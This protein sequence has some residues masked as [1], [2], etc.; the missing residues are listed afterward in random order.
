MKTV[1]SKK[2][3]NPIKPSKA[4]PSPA[5]ETRLESAGQVVVTYGVAPPKGPPDQ[6]IH[7]RRRLADVPDA[8]PRKRDEK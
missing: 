3:R 7:P 6:Q 5:P 2:S 4:V 1:P 8:P